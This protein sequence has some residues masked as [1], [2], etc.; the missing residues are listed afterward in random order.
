M[1]DLLL[2]VILTLLAAWLVWW[3][4][5]T[6]ASPPRPR[7]RRVEG[8]GWSACALAICQDG[9]R[10]T[11]DLESGT[12][13]CEFEKRPDTGGLQQDLLL[14]IPCPDAPGVAERVIDA[15]RIAG[16]GV[17]TPPPRADAP[18]SARVDIQVPLFGRREE[19]GFHSIAALRAIAS[20]TSL[21]SDTV[22]VLQ[23]HGFHD[24]RLL[25][26]YAEE[27]DQST[28]VKRKLKELTELAEKAAA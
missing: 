16:Y 4:L 13:V 27:A 17:A 8:I 24:R 5:L 3:L 10:L 28:E 2:P 26:R 23:Q 18:Q 9:V 22:Y 11:V 21:P 12:R 14:N 20:A 1:T 19:L 15:L 25:W 7:R 6:P